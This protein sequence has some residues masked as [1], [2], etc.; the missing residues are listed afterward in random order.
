M[1]IFI[2]QDRASAWLPSFPTRRSSDLI[3][4]PGADVMDNHTQV[5]LPLWL[6]P[7][8][9][10]QRG[11]HVLYVIARLYSGVARG[12]AKPDRKSTRLNSSHDSI[13]YAVFCLT[14]KRPIRRT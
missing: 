1:P 12:A 4:P 10:A 14:K 7:N 5:W 6:H 11:A 3:M 2:A 13:S 9:A 8:T